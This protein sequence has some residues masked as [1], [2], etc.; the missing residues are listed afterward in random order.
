MS[1][2]RVRRIA[3]IAPSTIPFARGGAEH[4]WWGLLNNLNSTKGI[5]AELIKVRVQDGCLMGLLESYLEF[6][7]LDLDDFDEVIS[8]RYPAWGVQHKN[9]T[10]FMQHPLRAVY[11]LYPDLLALELGKDAQRVQGMAEVAEI[12][13]AGNKSPVTLSQFIHLAMK[14]MKQPNFPQQWGG[15]QN[16][17]S[18]MIIRHIDQLCFSKVNRFSAISKTV[19]DREGYFPPGKTAEVC[20]HPSSLQAK[21][22]ESQDFF[23]VASRLEALKRVD[24][25]IEA[26]K[27][28]Q[29]EVPLLIAGTGSREAELKKLA[30]GEDGIQFLGFVSDEELA[31]Y[32]SEALAV[33]FVPKQEDFGLVALEALNAA[34]PVLTCADSGGPTEIIQHKINGWVSSPTPEA[35]A[36]GMRFF[37][38]DKQAAKEMG[39]AGRE[40]SRQISWKTLNQF[41]VPGL[42][43]KVVVV[44]GMYEDRF[45]SRKKE[46][47]I[48]LLKNA[49]SDLR[50]SILTFDP[51][52]SRERIVHH[53][54][55]LK[56]RVVPTTE[57]FDKYVEES[58]PEEKLFQNKIHLSYFTNYSRALLEELEDAK[59]ILVLD[60]PMNK[61]VESV[62]SAKFGTLSYCSNARETESWFDLSVPDEVNCVLPLKNRTPK[63]AENDTT[64][65][66]SKVIGRWG[67]AK[68]F[69]DPEY[70]RFQLGKSSD[71]LSDN[72]LYEDYNQGGWRR[73]LD[74]APWISVTEYSRQYPEIIAAGEEPL[75]HYFKK[76]HAEGVDLAASSR[77]IEYKIRYSG[78]KTKVWIS[79]P[80]P[81]AT[82]LY[83]SEV[84]RIAGSFPDVDFVVPL[85]GMGYLRMEEMPKNVIAFQNNK[86]FDWDHLQALCTHKVNFEWLAKTQVPGFSNLKSRDNAVDELR[87]MLSVEL[88]V[89]EGATTRSK[90]S[91]SDTCQNFSEALLGSLNSEF[92]E[93]YSLERK[94]SYSFLVGESESWTVKRSIEQLA[95]ELN[96]RGHFSIVSKDWNETLKFDEI[97]VVGD[98]EESL[99]AAEKLEEAGRKWSFVPLLSDEALITR[100]SRQFFHHSR[101]FL[102]RKSASEMLQHF[103]AFNLKPGVD[104]GAVGSEYMLTRADKIFVSSYVEKLLIQR[105][106]P[107]K[108]VSTV[109][110]FGLVRSDFDQIDDVRLWSELDLQA[111]EFD[112]QV[113]E[114]NS[115][116]NQLATL[117]ALKNS[118][119]PLVFL[120]P[121][122]V[123]P[124]HWEVFK[125]LASIRSGRTLILSDERLDL[126]EASQLENFQISRLQRSPD[127]FDLLQEFVA[128][129]RVVFSPSFYSVDTG[130]AKL[131]LSFGKA[132]VGG[133]W[134][135]LSEMGGEENLYLCSAHDLESIKAAFAQ[136]KAWQPASKAYS[137][138]LKGR[139]DGGCC[140]A[141]LRAFGVNVESPNVS[142]QEAA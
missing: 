108:N 58:F 74:P 2:N 5:S 20:F 25:V 72:Q 88:H 137:S 17:W 14:V 68:D 90:E 92:L 49:S 100:P 59:Q 19:A 99:S 57:L 28:A 127:C 81:F 101:N 133:E 120:A 48:A 51:T 10:V 105:N 18:R 34:K 8:T 139:R 36:Q 13:N 61:V 47:L 106:Y 56:E 117:L 4:F 116:N 130:V 138:S 109:D 115:V 30:A 23:F 121:G 1:N 129:A 21:Q 76:G 86:N 64:K 16:P 85:F 118:D 29:T 119:T 44:A 42:R 84:K 7:K 96:S 55:F 97:V 79:S 78:R 91:W 38:S 95:A 102:L 60:E 103:A 131:A 37:A 123:L 39:E 134:G 52:L 132:V 69:F 142:L 66:A 94:Q 77:A 110:L 128:R 24:L 93:H 9:H 26:W 141:F 35:I 83:F 126:G 50:F 136:A 75:T 53:S 65:S 32:Y 114:L 41:L 82:A 80:R 63:I 122:D 40:M 15:L 104:Q 46:G 112:L 62:S 11:D 70:Y 27:E 113:G 31:R 54:A 6:S 98:S 43:S 89:V 45:L 125:G 3:I 73:G 22:S 12:A 107:N 87:N 67:E 71:E 111:G 135:A 124:E 33:A 140:Q